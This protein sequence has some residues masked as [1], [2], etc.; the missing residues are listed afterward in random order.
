[1]VLPP[2]AGAA[3]RRENPQVHPPSLP[4]SRD[5][6]MAGIGLS[7]WIE[8][9]VAVA[10]VL[11]IVFR[12][13]PQQFGPRLNDLHV[14]VSSYGN[15]IP[16]GWGTTR[17]SG[18]VV[19]MT[20][21]I[22]HSKQHSQGGS[23]VTDY[24]YTVS[25]GMSLGAGPALSVSRLWFDRV[26]VYDVRGTGGGTLWQPNTVTAVGAAVTDPYNNLQ[27]CVEIA[28]DAKTGAWVHDGDG[29]V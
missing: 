8:I 15:V 17:L 14:T 19:A 10:D 27:V 16:W 3:T 9:G 25:F 12:R 20:K 22:E 29:S 13:K 5:R 1:M 4:A 18:N 28:G 6:L 21:L 11:S 23:T 2:R 24:T 7:G 26:L